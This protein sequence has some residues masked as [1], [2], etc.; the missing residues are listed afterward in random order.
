MVA[1]YA[2]L[3]DQVAQQKKNHMSGQISLFDLV[4]EEDKK[5]FEVVYPQVGEFEK[6]MLL[7]FEKEVLGIYLSGHPLE[8]YLDK[9]KKNIT[10]VTMDF[11][12]DE[13][14]GKVKVADNAHVVVGG[15]IAGRKV[16]YTRQNQAMAFLEIEDLTG[17]VEVIVFPKSYEQ[18]QRY[19]NP[20][21]KIFVIGRATIEDEQNGKIICERIVPFEE[22]RKELWIQFADMETYQAK[23]GQLFDL[24]N[25]SDGDDEVVIYAASQKA[26]KRL[27]RKRTVSVNPLLLERLYAVF[28]E[29]N[30]KVVEKNIE[31]RR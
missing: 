16:S 13:E 18:Y 24:L 22:T 9:I 6:E 8:Q 25:E 3:I 19:L 7:G 14:T 17:T 15:M 28:D 20:D 5:A 1:V 11:V 21:S 26:V 29:K 27:G 2:S 31:N 12:R 30:V 4:P 23:E 10:A